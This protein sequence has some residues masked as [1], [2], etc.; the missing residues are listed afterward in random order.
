MGGLGIATLVAAIIGF[1]LGGLGVVMLTVAIIG[2]L[3][4]A[5]PWHNAERDQQKILYWQR[6]REDPGA[7][8][9]KAA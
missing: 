5:R 8:S 7:R 4:F 1:A 2:F 3:W 9:S 6:D